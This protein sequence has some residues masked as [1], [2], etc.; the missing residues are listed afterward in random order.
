MLQINKN[1]KL[2]EKKGVIMLSSAFR[3][4]CLQDSDIRCVVSSCYNC[5][6]PTVG[7]LQVATRPS[8]SHSALL[9]Q[10]GQKSCFNPVTRLT[11]PVVCGK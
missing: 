11:V 3:L 5:P 8:D 7:C 4:K 6:G 1:E 10:S 9:S 2:G